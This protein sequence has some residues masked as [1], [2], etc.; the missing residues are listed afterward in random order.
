MGFTFKNYHEDAPAWVPTRHRTKRRHSQ[1]HAS[2]NTRPKARPGPAT[3]TG[4]T[5]NRVTWQD[6]LGDSESLART[7]EPAAAPV[8]TSRVYIPTW[9]PDLPP[10][11]END[12]KQWAVRL[13]VRATYNGI[14]YDSALS[15]KLHTFARLAHWKARVAEKELTATKASSAEDRAAEARAGAA[16]AANAVKEA[17]KDLAK[18]EQAE[19]AAKRERGAF[20]DKAI[21]VLSDQVKWQLDIHNEECATAVGRVDSAISE[22]RE[23]R[24]DHRAAQQA[25]NDTK[26]EAIAA[27]R[28]LDAAVQTA[29]DAV[30]AATEAAADAG[31]ANTSGTSSTDIIPAIIQAKA[32]V[33]Q[34]IDAL[35]LN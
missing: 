18:R 19:A 20:V 28:V 14:P 17:E 32:A 10:G 9:F 2:L 33:D 21:G 25:V 16:M 15:K 35:A 13:V 34:H 11:Y 26:A 30:G 5:T 27:A 12:Q 22:L 7:A 3:S 31:I 23:A 8:A 1:Q 4:R 6:Q 29:A 24:S